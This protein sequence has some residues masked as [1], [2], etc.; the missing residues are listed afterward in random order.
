MD[1]ETVYINGGQI[2]KSDSVKS[3]VANYTYNP[4]GDP[5]FKFSKNVKLKNWQSTRDFLDWLIV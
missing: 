3:V 4:D 1:A 5:L 2:Y